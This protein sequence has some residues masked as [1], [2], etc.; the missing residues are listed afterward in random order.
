TLLA[1]ARAGGLP[2][3]WLGTLPQMTAAHRF[4]EKH[5]FARI[6]PEALPPAYP[7]MPVDTVFYQ[8]GLG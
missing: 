5:G 8:R 1:Q 3:I 4:Y 7:R 2:G 6:A